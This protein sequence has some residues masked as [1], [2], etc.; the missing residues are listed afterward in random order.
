VADA[1][2]YSVSLSDMHPPATCEP[3]ARG[4]SARC[5]R[6]LAFG[7]PHESLL[8]RLPFS[9]SRLASCSALSVTVSVPSLISGQHTT[10]TISRPPTTSIEYRP[11]CCSAAPGTDSL[12]AH[13][14]E[15]ERS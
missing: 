11:T 5:C 10:R 3:S 2:A 9:M 8:T 12:L 7:A 6:V 1:S 13:Q 4:R 14:S 15:S